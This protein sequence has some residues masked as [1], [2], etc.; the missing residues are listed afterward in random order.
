MIRSYIGQLRKKYSSAAEGAVWMMA[1]AATWAIMVAI[2]RG[3]KD[4]VHLFEVVFFRSLFGFLFLVPLFWS[5]NF[6][7]LKTSRF[8]MHMVR[9]PYAC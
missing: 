9:A 4:D 5:K 1:S 7:G 8:S 6:T 2:A 3:L